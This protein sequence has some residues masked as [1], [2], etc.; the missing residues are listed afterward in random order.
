[1]K[2]AL[3]IGFAFASSMAAAS[4]I[5]MTVPIASQH[6]F[7][8]SNNCINL[9]EVNL[10]LGAEVDGYG[11]ISFENSYRRQSVAVYKAF[12]YDATS[13]MG[14]GVRLGGSTGYEEETD[15]PVVPLAQPY[16]K[17]APF[18][19]WTF[20]LGMV[21]VGLVDTKHYNLVVTLDSQISF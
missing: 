6:Y 21:P 17:L 10:G 7:C 20:N 13:Y 8:P 5:R 9:N 19:F 18:D 14:F 16:L 12:E 3:A 2:R 1:M 11:I 15:M 4:D